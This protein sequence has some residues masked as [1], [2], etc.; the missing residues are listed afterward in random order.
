MSCAIASYLLFAF[1][2]YRLLA[3]EL[4]SSNTKPVVQEFQ[5]ES[6]LRCKELGGKSLLLA[7]GI[8]FPGGLGSLRVTKVL[9]K[10][11]GAPCLARLL[12]EM[13]Y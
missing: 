12:M 13:V 2:G 1:P 9:K 5:S 4:T 6:W 8:W 3:V 10:M 11:S 7:C